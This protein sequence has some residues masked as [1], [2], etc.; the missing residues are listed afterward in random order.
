[1][2]GM[3]MRR[4]FLRLIGALLFSLAVTGAG[5]AGVTEIGN[6]QVRALLVSGVPLYDLRRPDEWQQ[7]GV[8]AG[9]RRLTFVDAAGQVPP[10]FLPRLTS[11]VGKDAPVI[12]VCRSGN[13]SSVLSRYLV[14][15]LGY[16]RVYNVSR[17]MVGWIGDGRPVVRD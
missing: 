13:R 17:G 2:M 14:E 12:L 3:K 10:D 7:T 1:M 6:E 9:S 4:V 15:K 16:T 5:A 8:I 11:A